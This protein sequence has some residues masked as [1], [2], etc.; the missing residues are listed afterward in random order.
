MSGKAAAA[1]EYPPALCKAILRGLLKQRAADE[2]S[3]V[4]TTPMTQQ[5]T[6]NFIRS[7]SSVCLGKVSDLI[8]DAL[9]KNRNK[10]KNK[11]DVL[12][13]EAGGSSLESEASWVSSP[14]SLPATP[15]YPLASMK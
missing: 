2:S 3:G 5:K 12:G 11:F 8:E 15:Q 14:M 7:L 13:Y 4:S 10:M 1:Q 9:E 6:R